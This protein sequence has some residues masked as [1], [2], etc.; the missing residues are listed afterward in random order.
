[1]KTSPKSKLLIIHRKVNFLVLLQSHIP[2]AAQPLTCREIRRPCVSPPPRVALGQSH[3][4][5]ASCRYDQVAWL[6]ICCYMS[7]ICVKCCCYLGKLVCAYT[8]W[9]RSE[10][11]TKTSSPQGDRLQPQHLDISSYISMCEQLY[12]IWHIDSYVHMCIYIHIER[13]Y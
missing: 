12:G 2:S 4:L 1:M 13:I 9:H 11:E 5:W 3:H 8:I 7:L 6:I 10:E